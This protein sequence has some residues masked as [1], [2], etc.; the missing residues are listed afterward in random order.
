MKVIAKKKK[1]LEWLYAI[2]AI[3]CFVMLFAMLATNS[4]PLL[5]ILFL[6]VGIFSAYIFITHVRTPNDLIS[7]DEATGQIYLH[8]DDFT[9]FA[10]NLADISYSRATA[11]SIKYK[12][13]TLIIE[14]GIEKFEIQYVADVENVAKELTRI[15]YLH[16]NK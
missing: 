2:V 9:V 15:M 13:G 6:I 3:V 4:E 1:G 16:K 5:V 11:R 12:W 7:V 14:T 10:S 8:S